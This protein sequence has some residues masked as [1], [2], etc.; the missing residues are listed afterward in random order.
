MDTEEGKH[1]VTDLMV[2]LALFLF[3]LYFLAISNT[4][5]KMATV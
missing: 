2:T 3:Y 5:L 4:G 1:S